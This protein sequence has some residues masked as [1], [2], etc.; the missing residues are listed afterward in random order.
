MT[1]EIQVLDISSN[2]DTGGSLEISDPFGA[3]GESVVE[4]RVPNLDRR[5][6]VR[7]VHVLL[8]HVADARLTVNEHPNARSTR[9][10]EQP[11]RDELLRDHVKN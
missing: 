2:I 3:I 8:L 7:L 11:E 1:K 4:R 6:Q 10:V 9:Y 5:G